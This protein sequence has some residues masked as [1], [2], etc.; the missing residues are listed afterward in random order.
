MMC[1]V[2]VIYFKRILKVHRNKRQSR[3]ERA[4]Q[5]I[6]E[7]ADQS[8]SGAIRVENIRDGASRLEQIELRRMI[9]LEQIVV[10]ASR[11][12]RGRSERRKNITERENSRSKI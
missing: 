8:M 2:T 10:K 5:S 3:S 1:N 12:K 6:L 7:Q 9:R 11:E 4:D